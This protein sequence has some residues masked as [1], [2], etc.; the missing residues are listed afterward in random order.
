LYYGEVAKVYATGSILG[1]G[2]LAT[3]FS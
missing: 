3:S 1:S 2:T